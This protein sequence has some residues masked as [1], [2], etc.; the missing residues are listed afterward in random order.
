MYCSGYCKQHAYEV[1]LRTRR[2]G[3]RSEWWT[4]P[5]LLA[6]VR[7][8]QGQDFGLDAAAC[9]VSAAAP[10]WLGPTHSDVHRRDATTYT[11]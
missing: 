9:A 10:S 11:S 2:R 6:R 1:R 5:E 7:Q 3:F 8:E 4:P